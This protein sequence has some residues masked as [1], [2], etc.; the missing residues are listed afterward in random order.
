M[1][2]SLKGLFFVVTAAAFSMAYVGYGMDWVRQRQALLESGAVRSFGGQVSP[3]APLWFF[4]ER[5]HATIM[6]SGHG[7]D[8]SLKA[9]ALFPE[10]RIVCSGP[11]FD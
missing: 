5:G 8:D 4:R 1:R 7:R 2:F 9:Q 3:P 6:V 11:E 10:A